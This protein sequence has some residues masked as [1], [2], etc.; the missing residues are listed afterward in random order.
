MNRIHACLISVILT[1]GTS[2]MVVG[3]EPGQDQGLKPLPDR[4]EAP[5][6]DL[7]DP[8]KRPQRLADYKGRPLI[9]NFWATWCP[10]C[11]KEMPS[12]QRAHEALAAEGISVVA[13]NV[14]EDA[15]TV[16]QF[17]SEYPV[18]FPLPMDLDMQ[19]VQRYPVKGLPTTF[20]IDSE[21]RL[22]YVATGEREW[23][24][25]A[26]LEQVRALAEQP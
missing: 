22:A 1:L 23:D 24:D 20:V 3:A 2:T 15:G 11:R 17:Q 21:G 7:E 5:A 13:I 9:L 12:M 4:P 10:P 18:D 26:L 14:G 8:A 19:V 25:P 16:E 6:F